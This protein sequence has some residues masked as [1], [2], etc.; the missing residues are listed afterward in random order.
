MRSTPQRVR[1]LVYEGSLPR[2]KDGARNLY[3]RADV[4]A[5]LS[6]ALADTPTQVAKG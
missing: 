3:R 1:N 6:G 4:E 2:V 5:Y